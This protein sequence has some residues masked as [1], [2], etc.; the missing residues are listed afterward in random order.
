MRPRLKN[1]YST[2][3]SSM[4]ITPDGRY[5]VPLMDIRP[6]RVDR[7]FVNEP[8]TLTSAQSGSLAPSA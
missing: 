1:G 4:S 3:L 2:S 7:M 8:S 5:P 6:R